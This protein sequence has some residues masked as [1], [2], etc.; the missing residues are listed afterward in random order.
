MKRLGAVCEVG[1]EK[2]KGVW[3]EVEFVFEFVEEFFM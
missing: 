2:S 1:G 3:M